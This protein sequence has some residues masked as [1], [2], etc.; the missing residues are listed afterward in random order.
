VPVSTAIA[1]KLHDIFDAHAT[2]KERDGKE[3]TDNEYG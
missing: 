2:G 1:G 3:K